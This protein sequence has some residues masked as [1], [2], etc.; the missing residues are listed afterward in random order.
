MPKC[1]DC[2]HRIYVRRG[3]IGE[4]QCSFTGAQ[5]AEISTMRCLLDTDHA[6]GLDRDDPDDR[7]CPRN[8][9]LGKPNERRLVAG[10]LWQVGSRGKLPALLGTY[11]EAGRRLIM[12][13]VLAEM[14][15]RRVAAMGRGAR[16]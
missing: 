11:D 9:P 1:H 10:I 5:V 7:W 15:K 2:P 14:A 3:C 8:L 13:I 6:P 12:E 16:A 4:Y